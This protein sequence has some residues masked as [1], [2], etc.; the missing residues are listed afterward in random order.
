MLE[1]RHY[2]IP[3]KRHSFHYL[4]VYRFPIRIRNIPKR[5][6]DALFMP[7]ISGKSGLINWSI[8]ANDSSLDVSSR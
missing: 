2:L 6:N 7:D 3:K 4:I 5:L 1:G 8:N